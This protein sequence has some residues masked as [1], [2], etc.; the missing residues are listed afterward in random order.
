MYGVV[1]K[2]V[3]DD[4]DGNSIVKFSDEM[5]L[6]KYDINSLLLHVMTGAFSLSFIGCT[7]IFCCF[8]GCLIVDVLRVWYQFEINKYTL[9]QKQNKLQNNNIFLRFIQK[10][11]IFINRF[12]M[13]D[14]V[15]V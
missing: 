6:S 3:T 2:W 14:D 4:R 11:A 9:S 10:S 13:T 8:T 7:F 12:A 5:L 15:V 1:G